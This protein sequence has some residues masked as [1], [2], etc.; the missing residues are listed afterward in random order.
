MTGIRNQE[1]SYYVDTTA[2]ELTPRKYYPAAFAAYAGK[3]LG[4]SMNRLFLAKFQF[5]KKYK[6]RDATTV[7][8]SLSAQCAT[9]SFGEPKKILART[10][11]IEYRYSQ[12]NVAIAPSLNYDWVGKVAGF[13]F[14]I[15]VIPTAKGTKP[16]GLT[17]GIDLGY[18]SD[19]HASFAIFIGSSFDLFKLE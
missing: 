17:G 4:D 16:S 19:T 2:T 15:Y 1:H 11:G 8:L 18:R 10:L 12:T 7:C 6:D 13:D 5:A 9:G 3:S 14:P